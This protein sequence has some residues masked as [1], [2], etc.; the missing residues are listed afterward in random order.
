MSNMTVTLNSFEFVE[1]PPMSFADVS[2]LLEKTIP[3]DPVKG[4]VPVYRFEIIN[5]RKEKVGHIS[6]KVGDVAHI[7]QYAGHIGYEV[8]G[9]HR[10][11]GYAAKACL[12]I[13]RFVSQYYDEVI[14]TADPDNFPSL[15]TIANIGAEYLNDVEIPED[16]F[17]N[18]ERD[19]RFK[20]RFAWKVTW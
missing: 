16:N 7:R 6:F 19:I 1:P 4:L 13:R 5:R 14:I 3:A 10:G 18:R 15:K 8:V 2:L 20:K 11:K 17:M 9:R 12:A